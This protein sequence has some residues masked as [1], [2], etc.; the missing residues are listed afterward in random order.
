MTARPRCTERRPALWAAG[1]LAYGTAERLP[2]LVSG[3]EAPPL[4]DLTPL[5]EVEADMWATG[6][7]VGDDA[8]WSS[9]GPASTPWG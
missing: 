7:T 1:A 6:L 3:E 5:E 4:P 8:R 9:P 2:G